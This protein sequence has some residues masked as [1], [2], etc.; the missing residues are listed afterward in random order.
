MTYGLTPRQ[1]EALSFIGGF[2][3]RNGY[4]PSLDEVAKALGLSGKGNVHR[5]ISELEKRGAIR[6]LPNKNRS[7]VIVGAPRRSS[8]A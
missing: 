7:M 2:I 8:H 5:L 6:K 4:S 1:K 3:E